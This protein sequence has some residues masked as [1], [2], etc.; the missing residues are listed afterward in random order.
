MKKWEGREK[1]VS[2]RVTRQACKSLSWHPSHKVPHFWSGSGPPQKSQLLHRAVPVSLCHHQVCLPVQSPVVCPQA[3]EQHRDGGSSQ[4]TG[5]GRLKPLYASLSLRPSVFC[6]FRS[7]L[8]PH[9]TGPLHADRL[10]F[11]SQRMWQSQFLYHMGGRKGPSGLWTF[12]FEV[13]FQKLQCSFYGSRSL[14]MLQSRY[15]LGCSHL[16]A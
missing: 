13:E 6:C 7:V 14:M 1:A 3:K 16:K 2:S 4:D 9:K 8:R 15:W 12:G 5:S 10:S 11:W